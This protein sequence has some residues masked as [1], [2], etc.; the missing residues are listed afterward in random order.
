MRTRAKGTSR[1]AVLAAGIIAL[2]VTAVPSNAY[3]DVTGGNGAAL[4]GAGTATSRDG[5]KAPDFGAGAQPADVAQPAGLPRLPALPS[6]NSHRTRNGLPTTDGVVARN[7][8]PEVGDVVR[9]D[10]R[11]AEGGSSGTDGVLGDNAL[12]KVDGVS[13]VT[14]M[15][16]AAGLPR[17]LALPSTGRQRTRNVLPSTQGVLVNNAAKVAQGGLTAGGPSSVHGVGQGAVP[18]AGDLPGGAVRPVVPVTG[19]MGP[20]RN[21]AATEAVAD[22]DGSLWAFAAS[23]VLGVVAGALA[24]ARRVRLGGRR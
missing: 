19:E 15:S 9:T 23:G 12:P 2:G 6:T 13:P 4:L 7:A 8:L 17:L 11:R 10:N 1:A 24:L 5:A 22:E 21:V 14:D 3:A 18:G 16:Q 20:V